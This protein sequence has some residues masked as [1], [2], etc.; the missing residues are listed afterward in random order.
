MSKRLVLTA[1]FDRAPNVVALAELLTR[2]GHSIAL[3]LVVSPYNPRRLRRLMRQ[4]G[5]GFPIRAA[6]RLLGRSSGNRDGAPLDRFL[7][8]KAIGHTSLKNWCAANGV[9]RQ[10]VSDLN[11]ERAIELLRDASADGVVYGGGGI[12]HDGFIEAARGRILNAHDGPMPEI[13]GMNACEWS[14]LLGLPPGVT[15]HVID[16]G[17]DTGPVLDHLPL[18][19]HPGET[20]ERLR[21]RC[22]V[23]EI[24]GLVRNADR[25]DDLP[26]PEEATG[27]NSLQCFVLA[28][29]LR[30]LLAA[31]LAG[32]IPSAGGASLS[33]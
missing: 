32:S 7:A 8:D 1:G 20:I 33:V 28:D 15:I 25:I 6:R 2:A 14:L 18:A 31:R 5:R 27:D 17:I 23:L 16:R 3:V 11:S 10:N 22:T 29:A 30:E 21:S 13:R 24:E 26:S 4:Q 19:V 12:L 9:R